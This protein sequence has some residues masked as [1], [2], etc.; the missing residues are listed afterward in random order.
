MPSD[1]I[2]VSGFV[3]HAVHQGV[4]R[5]LLSS[6]HKLPRSELACRGHGDR[7]VARVSKVVTASGLSPAYRAITS[8]RRSEST[9][10]S[11]TAPTISRS[12]RSTTLRSSRCQFTS[13]IAPIAPIAP[14]DPSR[15]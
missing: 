15:T 3:I 5:G 4:P 8:L 6:S 7:R 10:S 14:N 1:V 12:T 13:P 2:V 9:S 11:M